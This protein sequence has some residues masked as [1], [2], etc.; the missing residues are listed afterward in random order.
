MAYH[1]SNKRR[2]SLFLKELIL[3]WI[4]T[5]LFDFKKGTLSKVV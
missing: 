4:L 5:E 2:G 3:K 1:N